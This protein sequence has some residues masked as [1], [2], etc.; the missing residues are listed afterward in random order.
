MDT[1]KKK[2]WIPILIVVIA[3]AVIGLRLRN[4]GGPEGVSG[5]QAVVAQRGPIRV[6]VSASGV[7]EPIYQVEVKSKA[8]GLIEQM[9]VEEGDSVEEGQLLAELDKTEARTEYDQAAANL[10]SAKAS[11][12]YLRKQLE[13]QQELYEQDLISDLEMEE[14]NLELVRAESQKV[15]AEAKLTA[16]KQRLDDT[17]VRAPVRGVVLLKSVEAGQ[18]ISS[19]INSYTGGTTVAVVADMSRMLVKT[20]VDEVDIGS[21][22]V[23]QAASV[24]PDAFPAEA[25]SGE[26]IR[27]APQGRME[28][29]VTTFE[30][31]VQ[32]PNPDLKLKAGMN[33]SVDIKV[34]EQADAILVPVEV[35]GT[36]SA[37]KRWRAIL[38]DLRIPEGVG[39]GRPGGPYRHFVIVREDDGP[40]LRP[41]EVGLNDMEQVEIVRGLQEGEEVLIASRSRALQARAE[42]QER[43]KS[44]SM[45]G[46]R[47]S[48]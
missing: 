35:V 12:Q 18:I 29:N 32:I 2:I 3:A 16:A 14:T 48:N 10:A 41:V 34:A 36:A 40:A 11:L 30:V 42:F 27:I 4:H 9:P 20:S 45:G 1:H 43:I 21:V 23:G 24:R 38:P 26:V 17:V 15:S 28:Q 31:T 8:S 39:G 19:G 5:P 47:K 25:S 46:F 22:E 6:I 33:C 44:R 13:R 7:L 37:L